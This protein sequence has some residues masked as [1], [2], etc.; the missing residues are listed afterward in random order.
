MTV[1]LVIDADGHCDEPENELAAWMPPEYAARAP[2]S[3]RDNLGHPRIIL[4]GRLHGKSEGLGPSVSGPFAPHIQ[5]GRPGMRD[6]HQRL[7]DM[8]EEG[9]DVAIIFG[10]QVALAVNGL[11]D[12]GLA[13][14][15]CHAVNRWLL[16]EYCAVAPRRL[17]AVGLIPCQDPPAAAQ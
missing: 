8:D 16:E 12:K 17:K 15:I 4:E 1:D 2:I 6:P 7:A 9:I 10:T 3:V 13:G 14:A 5:G 11:M